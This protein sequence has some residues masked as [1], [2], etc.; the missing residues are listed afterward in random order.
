MDC[1][2]MNLQKIFSL[3]FGLYKGSASYNFPIDFSQNEIFWLQVL[4]CQESK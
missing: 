4:P 3:E 2:R 1:N